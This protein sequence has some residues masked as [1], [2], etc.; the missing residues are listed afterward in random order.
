LQTSQHFFVDGF[1]GELGLSLP[2]SRP[3]FR[4]PRVPASAGIT[5]TVP[6]PEP[7]DRSHHGSPLPTWNSFRSRAFGWAAARLRIPAS[8]GMLAPT[9]VSRRC[10][11]Q[12]HMG[13]TQTGKPR[14]HKLAEGRRFTIARSH[15]GSSGCKARW[16]QSF[17]TRRSEPSRAV[18]EHFL[19][20]PVAAPLASSFPAVRAP[21]APSC[22][23]PNER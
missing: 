7:G 11:Q 21:R 5:L 13:V 22:L 19:C 15:V 23:A 1:I 10:L 9:G 4:E 8:V 17:G 12:R 3:V 6:E 18:G 14:A 16:W 2:P 20:S